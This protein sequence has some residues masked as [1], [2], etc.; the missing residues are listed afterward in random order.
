MFRVSVVVFVLIYACMPVTAAL[1]TNAGG[2]TPLVWVLLAFLLFLQAIPPAGFSE[3]KI[4]FE[5]C[6]DMMTP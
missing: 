3:F 2:Y 4:Y 1:A 6:A 5:N